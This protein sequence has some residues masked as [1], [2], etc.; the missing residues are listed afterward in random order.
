MKQRKHL[1]KSVELGTLLCAP[2][3]QRQ[4]GIIHRLAE[5]GGELNLGG[6]IP[7]ATL[8]A[9]NAYCICTVPGAKSNTPIVALNMFG[10]S[11]GEETTEPN[12]QSRF[13]FISHK[14]HL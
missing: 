11:R 5:K 4:V 8:S 3:E 9:L 13:L 1:P 10:A 12:V 14:I 7:A 6:N 2:V